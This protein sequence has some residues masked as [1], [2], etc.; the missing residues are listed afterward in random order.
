MRSAGYET[1]GLSSAVPGKD[2]VAVSC[3]RRLGQDMPDEQVAE[4]TPQG[5]LPVAEPEDPIPPF[6]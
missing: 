5:V 4:K 3:P 6:R 1:D 2:E